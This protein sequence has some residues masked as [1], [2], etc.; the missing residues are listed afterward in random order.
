MD[1]GLDAELSLN[2]SKPLS[3]VTFRV[4]AYTGAGQGPWTPVSTLTLV[5][6]ETRPI[7]LNI[8]KENTSHKAVVH[9]NLYYIG[10]KDN[11]LSRTIRKLHFL[12]SIPLE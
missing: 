5:T 7:F 2:L 8:P 3:N 12:A 6:G 11:A 10:G 9:N 1:T 4:C